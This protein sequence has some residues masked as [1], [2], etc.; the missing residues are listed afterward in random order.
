MKRIVQLVAGMGLVGMMALS[1]A[2]ALA[3]ESATTS[4]LVRDAYCPTEEGY[5]RGGCEPAA[6]VT[7]SAQFPDGTPLGTC[8]T[9]VGT[10]QDTESG[11]CYIEVPYDVEVLVTQDDAT[12][13]AGY[14]STNNPQRVYIKPVEEWGA[15]YI[16]AVSFINIPVDEGTNPVPDDDSEA[17]T[18]APGATLPKT[19]SGSAEGG[20]AYAVPLVAAAA[21]ATLGL[22]TRR[23]PTA[24]R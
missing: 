1:G 8:V 17:G 2:T 16:P 3:Q 5:A 11:Y 4:L 12:L 23:W 7:V 15:D 9:E 18:E 21:T 14:E 10:V 13:A 22:V 20:A 6:G 24:N 19:G